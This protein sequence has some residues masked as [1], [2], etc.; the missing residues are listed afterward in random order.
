ME[1][2]LTSYFLTRTETKIRRASRRQI[3]KSSHYSPPT[4]ALRITWHNAQT[5]GQ[6]HL[7]GAALEAPR[8]CVSETAGERIGVHHFTIRIK[9][10]RL[11]FLQNLIA[12]IIEGIRDTSKPGHQNVCT[13]PSHGG[14]VWTNKTGINTLQSNVTFLCQRPWRLDQHESHHE[15]QY[16]AC[17]SPK[18]H[19]NTK[20]HPPET[21]NLLPVLGFLRRRECP[22][23]F[24]YRRPQGGCPLVAFVTLQH[25]PLYHTDLQYSSRKPQNSTRLYSPVLPKPT[26]TY[27]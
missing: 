1:K 27:S 17:W 2:S 19:P 12:S 26:T 8:L 23:L 18:T 9:T 3:D 10:M 7:A 5:D 25:I 16:S 21:T 14:R 20:L 24:L 15:S 22:K 13:S 11:S 4:P 6:F